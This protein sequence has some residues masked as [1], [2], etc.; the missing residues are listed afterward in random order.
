MEE[1]LQA[2]FSYDE[3]TRGLRRDQALG[4]GFGAASVA[5]LLNATQPIIASVLRIAPQSLATELGE[6]LRFR[7]V[8]ALL[9]EKCLFGNPDEDKPLIRAHLTNLGIIPNESLVRAIKFFCENFRA[10]R[11]SNLKKTTITDV[12]VRMPQIYREVIQRQN[13]RCA[14]CGIELRYGENMQLDHIIP[15][16]LADDPPDGSNWQ[17]LC[18]KCNRGK[19]MLPYYSLHLV[20]TNWIK[21]EDE[22]GLREDVRYAVL[23][24]D[25]RCALTGKLPTETELTVSKKTSTGCWILDNLHAVSNGLSSHP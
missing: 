5:D 4:I 22:H 8:H 12:Y 21:P 6:I 14:V 7:T 13:G 19:G 24:R 2:L 15:W 3:R 16:H 23:I 18:E 17:F 10:K 11:R 9:P 25:G 1:K 20:G